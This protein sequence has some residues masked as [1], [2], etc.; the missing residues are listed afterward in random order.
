MFIRYPSFRSTI[1]HVC[2]TAAATFHRM[3]L[4]SMPECIKTIWKTHFA[5]MFRE[6][7]DRKCPRAPCEL[8]LITGPQK[9]LG[10]SL[11]FWETKREVAPPSISKGKKGHS[12]GSSAFWCHSL[13]TLKTSIELWLKHSLRKISHSSKRTPGETRL[14][15]YNFRKLFQWW[16]LIS[17]SKQTEKRICSK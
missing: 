12:C 2:P 6:S 5:N 7:P 1:F 13:W 17:E 11:K 10:G 4:V 8:E 15:Y 16:R 9:Q 14:W 3:K